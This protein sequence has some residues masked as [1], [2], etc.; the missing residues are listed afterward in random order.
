MSYLY[1]LDINLLS[2]ILFANILSYSVYCL[3]DL[4]IVSLA[5]QNPLS[6][7]WSHLFIFAFLSFILGDRSK[8]NTATI[9]VKDCSASAVF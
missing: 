2:L 4:M 9:Y 6:L 8:K 1:I 5:V 3:F 7:I